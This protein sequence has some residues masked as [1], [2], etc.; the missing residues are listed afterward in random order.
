MIINS[1]KIQLAYLCIAKNCFCLNVK[2]SEKQ[3]SNICL[4][5]TFGY[6]IYRNNI[7]NKY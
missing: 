2:G 7:E 3:Y 1:S 6:K 5:K 4:L